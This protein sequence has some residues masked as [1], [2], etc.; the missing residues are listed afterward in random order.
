MRDR[1]LSTARRS[2]CTNRI[3]IRAARPCRSGVVPSRRRRSRS[4]AGTREPRSVSSAP[5]SPDSPRRICSPRPGKKSSSSTTAPSEAVKP[6]VRP[7][8]SP[9]RWTT[10]STSSSTCT[11]TKARARSFE[12]WC[13]NRL[14]EQIVQRREDRLR[15]P[16][17]DG[18]LFLGGGDSGD[19]LDDELAAA[20]RAGSTGVRGS[21]GT[22]RRF[23]L[24]PL[25]ALSE[26][27]TVSILKY[28]AGLA[29]AIVRAGGRIYSDTTSRALKA[30]SRARSRRRA[31]TP[32]PPT[33]FASAPM[34]RSPTCSRRT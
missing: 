30:G 27:G 34:R 26:S 1:R 24:R 13:G 11:A 19:V 3:R 4:S 14:I 28:L 21:I 7:R 15:F 16:A 23:Q 18:Y 2:P 6:V 12:P 9:T 32:S 31:S 33:P 8:I 20:H 5:E 10:G 17:V 22:E 25:P 29:D